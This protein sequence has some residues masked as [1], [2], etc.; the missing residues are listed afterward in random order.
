MDKMV[1]RLT[2]IT[3]LL[4]VV[5]FTCYAQV[6]PPPAPPKPPESDVIEDSV[7]TFIEEVRIPITAKDANGRFDPTVELG[8]LMVRENGV[9]QPS[10]VCFACLQALC[11]L[12]TLEEI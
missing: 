5:S 8:D 12:S 1:F 11:W 6:N 7:K 4:S 9:V 10:R 2:L 3:A